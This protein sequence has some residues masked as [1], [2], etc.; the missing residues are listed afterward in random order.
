MGLLKPSD[1]KIFFNQEEIKE[2]KNYIKN[3][4]SYLPQDSFIIDGSIV[5]NIVFG[6]VNYDE[7]ISDCINFSNL[8]SFVNQL[9]MKEKSIV[10]KVDQN[11]L[12][13]KDKGSD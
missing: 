6:D 8:R 11:Y 3:K 2:N 5:D 7:K 1:G 4:I 9:P 13:D 10:V 12:M